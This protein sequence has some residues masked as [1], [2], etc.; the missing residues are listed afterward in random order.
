LYSASLPACR[1][2]APCP[3]ILGE[4]S[5][6][7]VGNANLIGKVF[8]IRE[9]RRP[10]VPAVTHIDGSGR[11]QTVYRSTSA[12]YW[13]LIDAFRALTGVPMLINTS[14]NE[15]EPVICRPEEQ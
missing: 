3:S 2:I 1:A 12:H 7:L 10:F 6:S 13:P 8:L 4:A 9:E 14:F 5:N 15:N 11:L